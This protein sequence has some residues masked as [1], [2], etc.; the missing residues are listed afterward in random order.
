MFGNGS[1]ANGL[2]EPISLTALK[3]IVVINTGADSTLVIGGAA[4]HPLFGGFLGGAT[5]LLK[6]GPG[7]AFA[8]EHEVGIAVTPG[9]NDQLKFAHAGDGTAPITY[10]IVVEGVD[11]RSC[12]RNSEF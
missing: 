6:V 1:L 7:G 12:N 11:P 9:T 4:S 3:R 10:E 5:D 8:W 2:N